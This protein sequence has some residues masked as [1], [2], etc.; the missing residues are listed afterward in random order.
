M[1]TIEEYKASLRAYFDASLP[2]RIYDAHFHLAS[3]YKNRKTCTGEPVDEYLTFTEGA[4]CRQISGGLLMTSPSARHTAERLA[5]E[6]DY[7]LGVAKEHGFKLGYVVS[8]SF[9]TAD[10]VDAYLKANPDTV[11]ALKPYLTYSTAEDNFEADI[12]QYAPEWMFEVANEHAMPIILHLSHYGDML[13]DENNIRELRYFSGKYPKARIVLAH[14]AM[15]HHVRKLR[16]GL[17]KIADLENIWFDCSGSS[18]TMSI[19]YCLKTFGVSRMMWG[20][21]FAFGA[22]TGRCIS[23]GA[24]FLGLHEGYLKDLPRDYRYEPLDNTT[25]CTL[26]LLEACELL[27]LG[28]SE[29]EAIFYDNAKALYG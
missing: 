28:K 15:G 19:Y 23:F 1:T 16:L 8:P 12:S 6:N 26:A 5:D 27:E 20:G 14:C 3:S 4:I 17:Q 25:E 29:L 7:A 2:S 9:H 18:E 10:S 13:S 22:Q 24:N 11:R 21:D